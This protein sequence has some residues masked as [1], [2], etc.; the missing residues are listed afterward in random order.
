MSQSTVLLF[1]C[2]LVPV[3][4]FPVQSVLVLL[5]PANVWRYFAFPSIC[6]DDPFP[7]QL[8]VVLRFLNSWQWHWFCSFRTW[9][10]INWIFMHEMCT[11]I[12]TRNCAFLRV[13]NVCEYSRS[14][15]R[16]I[17]FLD[18]THIQRS[19]EH[20][21]EWLPCSVRSPMLTHWTDVTKS[22][23]SIVFWSSPC[24]LLSFVFRR[25]TIVRLSSESFRT[26][27]RTLQL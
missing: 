15:E 2:H 3:L 4:R 22:S 10:Q 23:G 12:R 21:N 7:D 18:G 11:V 14:R 9:R 24:Y 16:R 27:G 1:P 6:V 17:P 5:F 25:W 8:V 20:V 13:D 19:T 26:P